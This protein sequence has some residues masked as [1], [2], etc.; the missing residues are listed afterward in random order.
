[1]APLLPKSPFEPYDFSAEIKTLQFKVIIVGQPN[2]GKTTLLKRIM[3]ETNFQT[4]PTYGLNQQI[5]ILPDKPY[6]TKRRVKLIVMDPAGEDRSR[7]LTT[8]FSRL[9]AVIVCVLDLEDLDASFERSLATIK[10]LWDHS[11]KAKLMFYANKLDLVDQDSLQDCV[12]RA[13][14]LAQTIF[15]TMGMK[16]SDAFVFKA[17]SFI[18]PFN[19]EENVY[20]EDLCLAIKRF[21]ETFSKNTKQ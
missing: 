7:V 13:T 5:I 16:N 9:S 19:D 15:E 17:C 8:Q 18:A 20:I 11:P 21:M 3:G 14:E 4:R 2:V 10:A 1:M 6:F 12:H